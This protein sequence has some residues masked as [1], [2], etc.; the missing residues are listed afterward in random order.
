MKIAY[1]T[2][3]PEEAN[4]L[5]RRAVADG[6]AACVNVVF[7]VTSH[8]RWENEVHAD[9][10]SL[11]I[12]KVADDRAEE[13]VRKIREWHSYSCPEVILTEVT[14]GNPEYI[15]WVEEASK[16]PGL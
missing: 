5:A 11:L 8:Y 1:V 4:G 10:E 16:K 2:A 7:G 14:G 6:V 9:G 12:A 15:D 3:P 13:F